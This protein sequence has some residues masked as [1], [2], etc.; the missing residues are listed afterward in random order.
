MVHVTITVTRN[1]DVQI[2]NHHMKFIN[3][4]LDERNK[5]LLAANET[6]TEEDEKK[7]LPQATESRP[8][9]TSSMLNKRKRSTMSVASDSMQSP[10]LIS[11]TSL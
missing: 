8:L 5:W 4:L 1:Y 6:Q 10:Q 11:L 9:H 3:E 2:H 7:T